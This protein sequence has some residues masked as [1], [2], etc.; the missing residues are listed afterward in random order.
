MA[1]AFAVSSSP[2]TMYE[3]RYLKGGAAE[4]I[5]HVR[6]CAGGCRRG[7]ACGCVRAGGER[8]GNV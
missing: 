1:K 7:R 3:V 6:A 8:T 5:A 4:D 2:F